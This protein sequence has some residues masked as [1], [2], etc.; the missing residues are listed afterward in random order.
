MNQESSMNRRDAVR[1]LALGAGGALESA[2]NSPEYQQAARGL[3]PLRITNVKAILTCPNNIR[4]LVVV[5]VETSE[6]GLYGIG[7]STGSLRPY[8]VRS[9]VEDYL[10]PFAQNKSADNIEDLW[11]SAY[12][13]SYWRNGPVLNSALSG[14]D[15]ALWDIKAKRANMPLYHLLGG[16]CR[17]AVDCYAHAGGRTPEELEQNVR[18]YMEQGYRHVRIQLGGYGSGHL[19]RNAHFR[20]AGFGSPED[21]HMDPGP[22]VRATPKAFEHIRAKCGEE[23]ELLHDIHERI[24][25][26]DAINLCKRLEPYRP[27]FIEDPFAPE[28]IGYFHLLRQQTSTPVAMGE[29]FNN[30]HE[31]TGL[32]TGRLIDFIR[33][34]I[35]QIGGLSPAMKVARLAEWFNVR[36]AWHGPANVSPVGH[37]VNAHIDLAIRNFGIQERVEFGE[38]TREVFSGCP[39]FRNGYLFV[40]E[41]PGHG[42]DVNEKAAAKFPV[43]RDHAGWWRQVRRADGTSVRP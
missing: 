38:Q 37:A 14:L 30:P 2:G 43:P 39:A 8:A 35:S 23:V 41:A 32:I 4:T 29:L 28:D 9:A 26:L 33:I 11:Q 20:E 19:S 27:Y 34:H 1:G 16:K 36:T 6:P 12:V 5:K 10:K 22:Y 17:F 13:S 7:C 40:N 3:P 31:W 18:R 24:P 42:V 25:P 15:Q 21:E